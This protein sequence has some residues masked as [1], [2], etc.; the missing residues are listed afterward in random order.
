M[1]KPYNP[2]DHYFQKAKTAG[3][4]ARS[5]FKL[6][7]IQEKFN[8]LRKGRKALD[9]GAA[10]GSWLQVLVSLVGE[11]NVVGVDLQEIKP[12]KGAEI[13]QADINDWQAEKL[14]DVITADL[15]PNTMGIA[16]VD[17]WRSVELNQR[18]LEIAKTNL[19]HGGVLVSK[20]FVGADF[21]PFLARFKQHFQKT[22]VFK[23]SACRD[24]SHESYLIGI[25]LSK[26]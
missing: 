24:R 4:R 26:R 17:Q 16:D 13:I 18:V 14:F 3:Y 12:V 15:A 19:K 8:I 23:P 20:I 11:G 9:L 7:E 6:L 21:Q 25:G 2:Q 22:R 5:A 10:P 1:P